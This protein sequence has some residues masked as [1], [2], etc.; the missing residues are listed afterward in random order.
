M[1]KKNFL[2]I[3]IFFNFIFFIY[4]SNS[5]SKEIYIDLKKWDSWLVEF[6]AEAISSGISLNTINSIIPKIQVIK[7]VIELDRN[8][9][10]FKLSFEDYLNRVVS[11]KRVN[12][13]KK[14]FEENKIILNKV[15]EKLGVQPR[16]IVALWGIETDFGRLT[17][18]F[19]VIDALAT[20]AFEGRRA[21]Y[22][23]KELLNALKIID[24][25]HISYEKMNG[26]WAGAMGQPQFMPSSF[27]NFALDFD[28]DGKTDIWTNKKDIFASA[29]NYLN[30]SGWD[31]SKTWGREVVLPK[32]FDLSLINNKKE[33]LLSE[34]QLLGIRK[35]NGNDLPNINLKGRL[36]KPDKNNFKVFLV[37]DNFDTLLKWNRSN[38]FALSVG[39]LSD[40]I[41]AK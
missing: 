5:Y 38:Y 26:S 6:K 32:N 11:N 7:R 27:L 1:Y 22:F 29:S 25:G 15:S 2:N 16:F 12:K 33:K 14:L 24:E 28:N 37:Y 19:K 21:K 36:I 41:A 31:D 9:P 3:F 8:Q 34:W 10:E 4:I 20:L 18:G 40:K 23:R 30:K 39:I 17:G 35:K 13:G